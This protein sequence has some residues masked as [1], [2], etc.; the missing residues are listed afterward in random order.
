MYEDDYYS[1]SSRVKTDYPECYLSEVIEH[2]LNEKPALPQKPVAPIEPQRPVRPVTSTEHHIGRVV[3]C[4]L[5]VIGIWIVLFLKV[6]L[7]HEIFLIM[8]L[9]TFFVF[10]YLIGTINSWKSEKEKLEDY[11][12]SVNNYP[13]LLKKYNAE[14]DKYQIDK[15]EYDNCRAQVHSEERIAQF[16]LEN[17]SK[18]RREREA[19]VF[20]DREM[21]DS[22]QKGISE[23]YF[24]NLLEKEFDVKRNIKIPVG[25]SFYYPDILLVH[26]GL[27]IDI[28]ID[29]PYVGNEKSVIH[30]LKGNDYYILPSVDHYRNEYL[31]DNGWEIIRFSEEQVFLFPKE[32]VCFVKYFLNTIGSGKTPGT[33]INMYFYNPKWT[34]DYA[35]QLANNDYR[36]SYIPREMLK[37]LKRGGANITLPVPVASFN[38]Y[39][40]HFKTI[41]RNAIQTEIAEEPFYNL[42]F[43]NDDDWD[44]VEVFFA[45]SLGY[46]SERELES[47]KS[48]LAIYQRGRDYMFVDKA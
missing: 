11:K 27:Y 40:R 45:P 31:S 15:R 1:E 20:F 30:Y 14:K 9:V 16:R 6:E 36:N 17:I 41:R 33:E 34:K 24:Y 13:S 38:D 44:N 10:V 21:S 18:Y 5:G 4:V 28:E 23:D 7:L 26:D 47:M 22:V 29:E 12:K 8:V 43:Q 37:E 25:E 48:S 42:I 2:L 35:Q 3:A 46:L 32:C 39:A 19:P